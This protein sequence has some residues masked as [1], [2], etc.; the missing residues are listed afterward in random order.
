MAALYQMLF[1]LGFLAIDPARLGSHHNN[2]Q[3]EAW[4]MR[5]TE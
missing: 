2:A 1:L 4:G 5:Q 3:A